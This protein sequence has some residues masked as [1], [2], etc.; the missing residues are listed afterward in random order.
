M[1]P[2]E[3]LLECFEKIMI[4]PLRN[5]DVI[6]FRAKA[7]L[8]HET[9][10]RIKTMLREELKCENKILVLGEDCEIEILREPI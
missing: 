6:I 7:A 1:S 2:R 8:D 5:T 3:K 4:M 9:A 10:L